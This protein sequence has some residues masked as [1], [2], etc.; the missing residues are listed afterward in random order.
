MIFV[1]VGTSL[2]HDGLIEK[3]DELA[4]AGILNDEVIAQ[5]G[6][7]SYIPKNIQYIR[8]TPSS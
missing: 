5:I 6:A 4:G 7:G 8:F 3:I 2:P 1:T